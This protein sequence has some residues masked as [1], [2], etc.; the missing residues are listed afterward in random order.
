[1][2]LRPA[3]RDDILWLATLWAHAFPG[4]NSIAERARQLETGSA[5]GTID[6]A[7]IA[8]RNGRPVGAC[9]LY[10]MRQ[11]LAGATLPMMGLAAV[12]IAPEARRS[13]AGHELCRLALREARE[14]GDIVSVLYAF[15][16]DYYRAVG[17][18][19]V[20]ELHSY[21][22]RPEQLYARDDGCV[23]LASA[24]D[25]GVVASTYARMLDGAHGAIERTTAAW[26]HHL[27][28]PDT[29]VFLLDG[30]TDDTGY[31]LARYGRGAGREH[32]VLHVHELVAG[33]AAAYGRLLAWIGRQ[34]D[35]WRNIA[36]EASPDEHFA[37]QLRDP[38][39]A[40]FKPGRGLWDPVARVLRGPM[41]RLLDV[42]AALE[43][44]RGWGAAPPFSFVLAA[45]DAELPDN[46]LPIR[47]DWDGSRM[48]VDTPGGGVRTRLEAD[49][50]TLSQIYAGELKVSAA[51][52]IGAAVVEGDL[53]AL[54]A[55][56]APP[57]AFRLYD[58][59]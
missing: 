32:R 55:L 28:T 41:L 18:G 6:D 51:Q 45:R 36:Y 35:L 59:F 56:F 58:D 26:K 17:W 25:Y 43:R 10:R 21:R 57:R 13:G 5:Y 39:P 31:L 16:P 34:R 29:H 2:E 22:F 52:R 24:E 4:D 15:R 44:R 48:D 42:R 1:M 14:R 33:S 47:V 9:K 27:G 20:G 40:G 37:L 30:D 8:A 38:R 3:R 11:R 54:D 53:A 19:L 12:A 50:A 46:T 23:R 7:R 49:I